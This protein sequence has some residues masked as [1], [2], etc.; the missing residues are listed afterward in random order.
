QSN[1]LSTQ[2]GDTSQPS[3]S[4]LTILSQVNGEK[5]DQ[6]SGV[7]VSDRPL[8]G[9]SKSIYLSSFYTPEQK[10]DFT[11]ADIKALSKSHASFAATSEAQPWLIAV[12]GAAFLGGL[13]LNLMPCVLPVL[14][15]KVFSLMK[16][17]GENPRAAWIQGVAFTGGVVISFWMLA[18]LLLALR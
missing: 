1:V 14:S 16:H 17:A 15:L 6:L 8:I 3:D 18:G 11:E 12:L 5:S 10:S 2:P 9:D 13:I 4:T 7:L